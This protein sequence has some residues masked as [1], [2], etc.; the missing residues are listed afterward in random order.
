MACSRPGTRGVYFH[1]HLSTLGSSGRL[2]QAFP[3]RTS[4]LSGTEECSGRQG[5]GSN[6]YNRKRS[7][8]AQRWLPWLGATAQSVQ[9]WPSGRQGC[10][11]ILHCSPRAPQGDRREKELNQVRAPAKRLSQKQGSVTPSEPM[12]PREPAGAQDSLVCGKVALPVPFR[13]LTHL[14]SLYW[15]FSCPGGCLA[16]GT[17]VTRMNAARES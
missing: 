3:Y 13:A 14:S 12:W 1:S 11:R 6:S 2:G 5:Q 10:A 15:G 9:L 8:K 16:C 17:E 4:H 7:A